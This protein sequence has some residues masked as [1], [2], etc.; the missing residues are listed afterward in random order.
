MLYTQ[1]IDLNIVVLSWAILCLFLFG[2]LVRVSVVE[3]P[4]NK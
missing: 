4:S 2:H 3:S 1:L